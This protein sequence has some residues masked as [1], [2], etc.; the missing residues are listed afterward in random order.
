[1]MGKNF[2]LIYAFVAIGFILT[3]TM[4]VILAVCNFKAAREYIKSDKAGVG[5]YHSPII[6]ADYGTAAAYNQQQQFQQFVDQSN[7][8]HQQFVDQANQQQQQFMDQV[9]QQQF[10]QF[11][12]QSSM[13]MSMGGFMPNGF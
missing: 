3:T 10:D 1:M 8:Q 12:M 9:N 2:T 13:P 4:I 5:E 7:R 6:E 11:M